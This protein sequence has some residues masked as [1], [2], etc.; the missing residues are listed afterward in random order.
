MHVYMCMCL[1]MY[2]CLYVY[3]H[4]GTLR[5]SLLYPLSLQVQHEPPVA[6]S[7]TELLSS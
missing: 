5:L 3:V 2:A 6:G 4:T 7:L 1:C